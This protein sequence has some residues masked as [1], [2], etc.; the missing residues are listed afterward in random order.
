MFLKN[1][2]NCLC[3]SSD[4]LSY[5]NGTINS[6][7]DS[8]TTADAIA[9]EFDRRESG[10]SCIRAD[11]ESSNRS[12]DNDFTINIYRYKFT[13]E[14]MD[15]LYK[16]SKIHQYDTR[17]DF[18]EAWEKWCEDNEDIIQEEIQ[19]LSRLGFRGDIL[20]KMFK[21]ARYYFRKR[22]EVRSEEAGTQMV[23]KDGRRTY[24]G[25]SKQLLEV[26]DQH[27]RNKLLGSSLKPSIAFL[28]FCKGNTEL[29]KEEIINLMNTGFKDKKE[30]QNKI[31]KTYKNRYF[32]IITN[33]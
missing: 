1:D 13:Q 19:R 14:F 5:R 12:F 22:G 26:I 18:K 15:D 11:D 28:D 23:A 3:N 20:D 10:E 17:H 2:A 29:L 8:F 24:K 30:I 33:K 16:F 4:S 32:M 7:Y 27:I 6:K 25:S 21:S 31:K 9:N